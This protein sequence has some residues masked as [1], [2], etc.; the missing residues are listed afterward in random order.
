MMYKERFIAVIKHKGKVL[1]ER[2]GVARLPFGSEYSLMLKNLES[3]KAVVNVSIDGEDVLDGHSLIVQ[4]NSEMEL[5]GLMDGMSARN[6]FKFIRKT[7]EIA[8]HRGDRLD[9]GIVRVEFKFEKKRVTEV[10]EETRVTLPYVIYDYRHECPWCGNWPC[11]CPRWWSSSN[12]YKCYLSNDGGSSGE[13]SCDSTTK[14]LG[15]T[16]SA[17][18][19]SFTTGDLGAPLDDEGIT[20]KGS[21]IKQDF[22]YGSTYELEE[23]SS[24]IIIRLRGSKSN[25]TIVKK[26]VTVKTKLTCPTC[27]RKAKSSTKFCGNC[28]TCLE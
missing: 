15:G 7:K 11:T 17:N 20:V 1:R 26:P 5:K 8:D 2:G 3:R 16:C 22:T 14:G 4:P 21:K 12:T 19:L 6:K 9:D 18:N 28:G 27:G 13:F 10:V 25:G 24:V 23:S